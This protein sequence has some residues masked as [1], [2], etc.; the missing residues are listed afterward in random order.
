MHG[1]M[2]IKKNIYTCP[3]IAVMFGLFVFEEVLKKHF[4]FE[5]L[6]SPASPSSR[7][8][9]YTLLHVKSLSYS[10]FSSILASAGLLVCNNPSLFFLVLCTED[11]SSNK[12]FV[13]TLEDN[14]FMRTCFVIHSP[15][16]CLDWHGVS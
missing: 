5:T 15:V 12:L 11:V 3:C 9:A 6:S 13:T 1:T 8:S 7:W 2:N 14:V 4:I 16:S 10:L